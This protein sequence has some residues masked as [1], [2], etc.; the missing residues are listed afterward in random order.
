CVVGWSAGHADTRPAGIP[1]VAGP[2]RLPLGRRPLALAW[3]RGL[4]PVP[5]ADVVLAP[6]LLAPPRQHPLVVTIHDAVPWTHPD[7]L[8]RRG[9]AFHRRAA[10][11]VARDADAI[12]VPTRAVAAALAGW[13]DIPAGRLHVIG[14]GVSRELLVIPADADLRAR[15]LDLP[16]DGYLLSFATLEPRKGLDVALA[17]LAAAPEVTLPLVVAGQTGW[18]GVDLAGEARRLGLA[19]GRLRVLGR[20]GDADLAVALSRASAVVVP[21]RAEGFG[22]PVL[23]AM[24]HGVPVLTSDAPALVEVGAGATLVTPVGDVG[25]L[26]AALGRLVADDALRVRLADAGRR[27]AAQFS[28]DRAATSVWE[29]ARELSARVGRA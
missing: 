21:S 20:L 1:G 13:L 23:E 27:R 24:A 14:E 11:R 3:E 16:T 29:L 4:G 9:V 19:T 26:A 8:T 22:L 10:A 17:A 18:G 6:T 5:D 2:L 28:W 12:L 25:A 15:R 7:T